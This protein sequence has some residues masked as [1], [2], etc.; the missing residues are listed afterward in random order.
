MLCG[1]N[2]WEDK[3]ARLTPSLQAILKPNFGLDTSLFQATDLAIDQTNVLPQQV[4][5]E[6]D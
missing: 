3:R 6:R 4:L 5:K 2:S 1:S